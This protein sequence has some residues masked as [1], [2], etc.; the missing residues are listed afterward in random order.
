MP[1]M[2]QGDDKHPNAIGF[3]TLDYLEWSIGPVERSER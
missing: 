1:L 2:K 3:T